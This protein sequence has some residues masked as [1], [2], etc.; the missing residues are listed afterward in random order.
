[1][2]HYYTAVVSAVAGFYPGSF[3]YMNPA[4]ACFANMGAIWHGGGVGVMGMMSA[5]VSGL[6]SGAIGGLILDF[7]L[8]TGT[9]RS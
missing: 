8:P 3:Y 1:M 7:I 6:I 5:A 9:R 4:G 2:E